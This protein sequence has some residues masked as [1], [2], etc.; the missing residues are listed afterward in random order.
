MRKI[1][2]ETIIL[3]LFLGILFLTFQTE[4]TSFISDLG[5]NM[6]VWDDTDLGLIK[7]SN[8]NVYFYVN[9]TNS[10]TGT[11][12]LDG[13]CTIRFQNYTYDFEEWVNMSY[14][15]T[16]Q[17]FQYNKTFN[18]KGDFNFEI[19]CSNSSSVN[20]TD[21]FNITNTAPSISM[22]L[23]GTW[24]DFD[25]N[26]ETPDTWQCEEDS[27]CY[28]NFSANITEID[29]NDVLSYTYA[30]ENTTLTNYTLNTTTG[31]L[32]VNVTHSNYTGAGKKIQLQAKDD[33]QDA[34]WQTGWLAVDVTDVNDAPV[35]NGLE[36]RSFNMSFLFEYVLNVS[37][38]EGDTPFFLNISFI[39]CSTA[40]WSSRNNTNCTLFNS[41]YYSFNESTGELNISFIPS[42]DD[43]GEYMI[44]FSVRDSGTSN[45]ENATRQRIIN[46]TV[47]NINSPPYFRYVCDNEREGAEDSEFNCYINATDID[48][49]SNLTFTSNYSW[50]LNENISACNITTGYNSSVF[51]NFTPTDIHVG[52]W[53]INITVKDTDEPFGIN[54]TSIWFYV[55]NVNDSVELEDV[56]NYTAFQGNSYTIPVNATDSDLLISDKNV[57]SENISFSFTNMSGSEFSWITISYGSASGNLTRAYLDFTATSELVGEHTVN[58]TVYDNN[59]FSTDFSIFNITIIGNTAPLWNSSLNSSNNLNENSAYYINLSEF[60]EDG[61]GDDINFSYQNLSYFPGFS[62][63]SD[64]GEIDFTPTDADVGTHNVQI[65]ATDSKTPNQTTI[66]YS[67]NNVNDAPFI[68]TPITT[69]NASVDS[70]SNINC[71]EDNVT[72][73]TLNV[74]DN[75]FIIPLLQKSYYN[76]S[77]NLTV[78]IEGPNTN[79]F[80]FTPD[81]GFPIDGS[82]LSVYNAD[83][84]PNKSDIGFYNITINITDRSNVSSVIYF[85]LSIFEISHN[86]VN[87]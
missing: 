13:N 33:D 86:P 43:V 9:F 42:R 62:L 5:F 55:E 1:I 49:T 10:T 74:H 58:V 72:T 44:N 6:S 80:N 76:E 69:T 64:S 45:P 56:E 34:L 41:T 59:R 15:S 14:N 47:L 23:G 17:R 39:N 48:E 71:T 29:V 57:Y 22:R 4:A 30:Q 68:I 26:T 51:I 60:V 75:D 16:Y 87:A 63:D 81:S 66:S 67:V 18:Y 36:N 52:N 24:I 53:S 85:N 32:L 12:V 35:F 11:P 38:E 82:N 37:D 77:L 73:L 84:T 61:E 25:G 8:S 70:S 46:F 28:Y 78:E 7:T 27:E 54:E 40:E 31:V 2:K 79:L 19:N 83:F 50:F 20:L 65:T 3:I 21:V